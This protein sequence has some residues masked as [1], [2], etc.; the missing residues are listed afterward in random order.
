MDLVFLI[1]GSNGV[2]SSDFI[3]QKAFVSSQT[4]EYSVSHNKVKIAVLL[5]SGI[6]WETID[7]KESE[8][9]DA[10]ISKVSTMSQPFGDL[11]INNALKS[12]RELFHS[13]NRP[14]ARRVAVLITTGRS[15]RLWETF[16]EARQLSKY[17][18]VLYAVGVGHGISRNELTG[19][20]SDR[21]NVLTVDTFNSLFS[22]SRKLHELICPGN[23]EYFYHY[24]L[25]S[26][27]SMI[28]VYSECVT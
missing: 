10:F 13:E 5:Y 3:Q 4:M 20:T 12:V 14:G 21:N 19:L 16:K 1:D 11:F 26:E 18:I 17:N 9:E 6:V 15:N 7:F 27:F 28:A 23:C 22:L 2:S 8:I 25:H 24:D